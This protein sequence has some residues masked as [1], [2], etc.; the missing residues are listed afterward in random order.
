MD[1]NNGKKQMNIEEREAEVLS[2]WEKNE[3][4]KKTLEKT[5]GGDRFSFND[6]PPFATGLPHYGHILASVLKDSVLRFKTMQGFHV[7][8]VWGWDCHGLPI[9][10]LV[11]KEIGLK[12]KADVEEFGIDKF[13]EAARASVMKYDVE[14]KK[15]IPR[16]GRW[17]DMEGAYKT[18]DA[19]YIESVWWAFKTLYEKELIYKGFKSMQICPRCETTLSSSEVSDGYKDITDISVTARFQ[20]EGE[21][22]KFILAWTTTPWTLPG[23]VALAVNKDEEYSEVLFEDNVYVVASALAEKVFEGKEYSVEKKMKGEDLVGLKY[24][25]LFDYYSSQEGLKNKENGWKVYSADFVT[26]EDG[27]GIVHIAPAFGSDDMDLGKAN[28]L[29]F[30]QHVAMGGKMKPEVTDFAGISVKPKDDHQSMD[31]LI[32]KKLASTD[33]IF[34]KQK[35][36]HSYPHCWR[37]DSPLLNYAADSWFVNVPKIKDRLMEKNKETNWVPEGM[38]DGRFGNW[39]ENARDWAISRSRFWGAPLPVWDCK[40]CKKQMVFG[41]QEELLAQVDDP[42]KYS[43]D[44]DFHRPYIDDVKVKCECGGDM[45]RVPYVFDCWFESGSMPYAQFHYPFENEKEFKNNFPA[46]FIAEGLDQTRGWFYSMMVLS[47]ALFDEVPFK[48]VIVNGMVLAED[49]QKM[50][51]KLKNYPD[52]SDVLNKYGA[53]AVRYYLLASPVVHAEY[54]SLSEKGI[55]E[56]LKK[57]IMR[58]MNVLSFYEMYSGADDIKKEKESENVLDKWITARL[59][60]LAFQETKSLES[61]ELDKAFRPIG[62]FVDDLSTWYIRR[63]RD[64]FKSDDENEKLEAIVTTRKILLEVSK[65]IAPVMPFLA[66]HIYK[67]LKGKEESVHL[68]NWVEEKEM[69]LEKDEE[70]LLSNMQEVRSVVSLALEARAKAGIKVRQPL[71]KVT[72]K[73][74]ALEE[75]KDL[76]SLILD[77]VNIKGISFDDSIAEDVMLDT[78]ITEELKR[79]GQFRDLV[80]I[81]QD[82]RKKNG[83]VPSDVIDLNV[84]TNEEG[85]SIVNEFADTLKSTAIIKNITFEKEEGEEADIMGT[86][87]AIS[88]KRL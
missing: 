11:E 63:S 13:N 24:K 53:D 15:M 44:F 40:E 27:T 82:I 19:G 59:K 73:N 71:A 36:V 3:I 14:W 5:K 60:E 88:I 78:E 42:K 83:L 75:E 81:V 2:F 48:N 39:L 12:N 58:L 6:G 20:I 74:K 35:M 52:P 8:R 33:S 7:R 57:V 66:E 25:P 62:D 1:N 46:D 61:Y 32:L 45:E 37:C 4:F 55:D 76:H 10:N 22:N 38:R 80:R 67:I 41:S 31:I 64:R 69:S 16:I 34:A 70:K 23:N 65:L 26:M 72:V 68:E 18:M 56:V 30:V 77:E 85:E 49:G 9:E 50:S 29:P 43:D 28:N 86:P 51:K 54:L 84:S 79:E 17:I 87:F 21:S 47:V